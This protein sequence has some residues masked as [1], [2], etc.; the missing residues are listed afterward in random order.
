MVIFS[1]R[2]IRDSQ[3]RLCS[4]STRNNWL[5]VFANGTRHSCQEYAEI[6]INHV[7]RM[8]LMEFL[9]ALLIEIELLNLGN[10]RSAINAIMLHRLRIDG[11]MYFL[12]ASCYFRWPHILPEFKNEKIRFQKITNSTDFFSHTIYIYIYISFYTLNRIWMF[13][14]SYEGKRLNR[15][16]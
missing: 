10:N 9:L 8:Y 16:K 12:T 15:I 3:C 6:K 1:P 2:S 5:P 4:V 7:P 11:Q 14:L 13:Y